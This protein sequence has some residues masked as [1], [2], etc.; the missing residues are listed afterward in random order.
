MS[1]S[2]RRRALALLLGAAGAPLLAGCGFRPVYGEGSA[3]RALVGQ[4][5]IE[6]PLS[7]L[8]FHFRQ[9]LEE[10]LG[11][12]G[13]DAPLELESGF[14]ISKS[15][16]AITPDN[17]ITRYTLNGIGVYRLLRRADGVVLDEG[18]VRTLTAY[19]AT[20]SLYATRAAERDAEERI[21]RDLAGRIATRIA[22]RANLSGAT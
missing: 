12:G 20:A 10:R 1:S 21:V 15:G 8:G 13:G 4:V 7:R 17:S 11:E 6:A 19:S 18:E 16:L 14:T 5:A 3:A 22:A 9:A 2:D